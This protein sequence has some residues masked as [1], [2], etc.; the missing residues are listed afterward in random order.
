MRRAVLVLVLVMA[1]V[2]PLA[3]NPVANACLAAGRAE[4]PSLCHCVGAA[5]SLTLTD[6]DQRRAAGF[7]A[8]PHAAQ[9]TRMSDRRRDEQ[10]W[11]R[12]LSFG[13]MAEEL[14]SS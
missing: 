9:E 14:C 3:A 11:D 5:A 7:F 10:F 12:Y 8:D 4:E 1:P 6:Q 2:A 13:E